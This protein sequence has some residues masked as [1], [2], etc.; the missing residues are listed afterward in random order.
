[1]KHLPVLLVVSA[2]FVC[3]AGAEPA[4]PEDWF[5][6]SMKG[7]KPAI[8]GTPVS[9][10]EIAAKRKIF[11][12]AYRNAAIKNGWDKQFLMPNTLERN[13]EGKLALRSSKYRI[14][15][16]LV[17]P[18]L[19]IRKGEKPA[20]GWPLA[21]AMHG[22]GS[23]GDKLENPHAWPVNTRE[24]N[25]Q[26]QLALGLYPTGVTYFIPR[27]VDD[28]QGRWWKEFNYEA[29]RAVIRHAILYWDVDPNRIYLLGISE[30]GYGTETLACRYPEKF[31]AAN[32][33]SCG[34]GTSIHV[35]NLRNL[36][37][38][39]DVGENDTMFGRRPNAVKKHALLEELRAADPAG[40]VNHL[41]VHAG[42]GHGINYKP[43][44]EWLMKFTRNP[45]PQRVTYTLFQHD[46]TRNEG[47]YWMRALNDLE[48]KV[49]YLDAEMDPKNNAIRI[50]AKASIKDETVQS[51]DAQQPLADAGETRAASGLK[52]RLWLH[53]SLLDLRKPVQV[54]INGSAVTTFTP[55]LDTGAMAQSLL[56]FGDPECIY[57]GK[58]DVTVP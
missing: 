25:A 29:F 19:A 21:I 17:M 49:I 38:R 28:N 47:A 36:P 14:R 56:A 2:L 18:Y 33:L 55:K 31:A 3:R 27:M 58:V 43:G 51:A 10:E 13:K 9:Y 48:K 23:T 24:W 40:Y 15:E 54:T 6:A 8:E 50:S 26:I 12:E 20:N 1:M 37:F 39:T 42:R 57:A 4:S 35:E 34:S 46:K 30:G 7:E 53:E 16:G 22:G 11:F 44:T 41:E 52:L 5:A 32:G 45:H